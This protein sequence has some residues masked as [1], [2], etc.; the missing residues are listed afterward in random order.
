[1]NASGSMSA[2]RSAPQ[3][4]ARYEAATVAACPPSF[5]PRNA[6]IST[7]R[8]SVG[9]CSMRRSCEAM[10][11]SVTAEGYR[12]WTAPRRPARSLACATSGRGGR[13]SAWA[14]ATVRPQ[15]V[16]PSVTWASTSPH[17]RAFRYW[18]SPTSICSTSTASSTAGQPQDARRLAPDPDQLPADEEEAD[19]E[20]R[21]RADVDVDG[22]ADL[23]PEPV[24]CV[25]RAR[26]RP[27]RRR[28]GAGDD[29]QRAADDADERHE[30]QPARR[31]RR[32][33]TACVA[34]CLARDH[35]GE[36]DDHEREQEVGHH[37][38]RMQVEDHRE[39]AERD[40]GDRAEEGGERRPPHPPRQPVDPARREPRD[41]R[42]Q[43]P[44]D[45]DDAVPE[46]DH[47][48]EVLRGERRVAAPRPVVAAEAR[49]GQ[50]HERARRDDER[51]C[52]DGAD[53]D[54]DEPCGETGPRR[55]AAL[56]EASRR[57][58]PRRGRPRGA[59]ARR[60]RTSPRGRCASRPEA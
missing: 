50:A 44:D 42:G 3:R 5:H 49:P 31:H 17:G 28:D 36:R 19:P 18:I 30:P 8:R 24:D 54:P 16:A 21:G 29:H 45:R 15:I 55:R 27:G 41:E 38:E 10:G 35:D 60:R 37:R 7:G 48:V 6:E 46:L 53:G 59:R 43:D 25:V 9:R 23:D 34:P 57:S 20:D 51:E 58:R 39:A 14:T 13:Q 12:E 40:L 1:M 56:T 33:T 11:D 4:R 52:R 26:V 32:A 2:N 22:V 47:R